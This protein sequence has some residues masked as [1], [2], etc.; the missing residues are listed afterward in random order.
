MQHLN[1][2]P[3]SETALLHGNHCGGMQI[4]MHSSAEHFSNTTMLFVLIVVESVLRETTIRRPKF[5]DPEINIRP[6]LELL[7]LKQRHIS[8]KVQ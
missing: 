6:E 3:D 8:G 7:G 5:P 4:A 1:W 2:I